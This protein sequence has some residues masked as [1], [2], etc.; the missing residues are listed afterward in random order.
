M[1]KGVLPAYPR[2]FLQ[3]TTTSHHSPPYPAIQCRALLFPA[4]LSHA[5]A[6][7][8]LDSLLSAP[9]SLLP[10][11]FSLRISSLQ[12]GF[13]SIFTGTL[14]HFLPAAPFPFFF[15]AFHFH[16]L[17]FF[18][19]NHLCSSACRSPRR[20]TETTKKARPSLYRGYKRASLYFVST[21]MMLLHTGQSV[22]LPQ[23]ASLTFH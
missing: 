3:L 9:Y 11:S 12:Y 15:H 18:D 2:H 10:A 17:H 21:T 14:Y 6:R 23:C 8:S 16:D 22:N 1:I 4:I 7:E 5:A 20:H 13:D 19:K